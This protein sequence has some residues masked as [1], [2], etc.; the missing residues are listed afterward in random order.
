[1]HSPLFATGGNIIKT[2]KNDKNKLDL[3]VPAFITGIGKVMTFGFNKHKPTKRNNWRTLKDPLDNY[4]A[5]TMR[6]LL[7]W[8]EGETYDPESGLFHLLHAACNIMFLVWFNTEEKKF[9]NET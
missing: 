4:Y 2:S 3:I 1:M 7:A 6:H 5:A 8:R 9:N